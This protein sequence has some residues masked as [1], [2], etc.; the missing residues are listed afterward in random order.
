MTTH[1]RTRARVP[2]LEQRAKGA[3][4][5][6]AAEAIHRRALATTQLYNEAAC[7]CKEMV[8]QLLEKGAYI[9]AD[10]REYGSAL[11]AAAEEGNVVSQ[12]ITLS[13]LAPRYIEH[14][15][16]SARARH[17]RTKMVKVRRHYMR[18]RP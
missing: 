9:H 10:G 18:M 4:I 16:G 3:R 15:L 2:E 5:G 8:Q 13:S 17:R 12:T 6:A 7:G 11:Q 1:A 14:S